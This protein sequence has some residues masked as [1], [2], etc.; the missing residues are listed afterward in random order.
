M[1]DISPQRVQLAS[2][3]FE[4]GH[5]HGFDL[6]SVVG[7]LA[8]PG[9]DRVL[10]KSFDPRQAAEAIACGQQG[11]R[12]EN[13]VLCRPLAEE[14]RARRGDKGGAARLTLVA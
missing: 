8:E 2:L 1:A 13:L 14:N 9:Q 12:F 11:Q 3:H 5:Q 4:L 6:I 10:P 7:R